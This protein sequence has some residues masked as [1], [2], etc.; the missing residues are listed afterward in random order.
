MHYP[1]HYHFHIG[2][3]LQLQLANTAL[4][5]YVI[6]LLICARTK[7]PATFTSHVIA[8]YV[9]E[10]NMPTKLHIYAIHLMGI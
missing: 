7:P 8:I 2:T 10:T 4:I 3:T 1:C 9:T 5:L 6:L